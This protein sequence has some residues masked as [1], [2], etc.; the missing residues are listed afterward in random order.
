MP[1]AVEIVREYLPGASDEELNH[2]LWEYTGYPEFW[3]IGIDGNTA[4]ECFR[5]QLRDYVKR[6]Q[7]K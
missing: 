7:V 5:K 6:D 2:V 1:T 4:E 3:R